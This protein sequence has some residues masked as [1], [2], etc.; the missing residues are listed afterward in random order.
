MLRRL[1]HLRKDEPQ[2]RVAGQYLRDDSAW[3]VRSHPQHCKDHVKSL[4]ALSYIDQEA[5][6]T[7]IVVESDELIWGQG[8]R[9]VDSGEQHA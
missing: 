8:E 1:V 5:P 2:D 6:L 3:G 9:K 7:V 4:R